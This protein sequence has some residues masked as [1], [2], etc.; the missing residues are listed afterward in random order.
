MKTLIAAVV[1]VT[2][3]SSTPARAADFWTG[4]IAGVTLSGMIMNR[5]EPGWQQQQ[6]ME[7]EMMGPGRPAPLIVMQPKDYAE[8][9]RPMEDPRTQYLKE[10]QR[11]GFTLNKCQLMWDSP[12]IEE[13]REPVAKKQQFRS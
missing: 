7:Y 5:T 4:M 13:E 12:A 11:Y 6:Q 3:I 10:C 2:A 1:A 9:R 8:I